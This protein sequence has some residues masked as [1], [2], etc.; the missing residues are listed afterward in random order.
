MY[1]ISTQIIK[2]NYS[3]IAL[4]KDTINTKKNIINGNKQ[5]IKQLEALLKK[6]ER[7]YKIN[8]G[9]Y[10][11]MVYE[12]KMLQYLFFY[13]IILLVVPL[14]YLFEIL[15][16]LVAV[17]GWL[18]LVTAGIILFLYKLYTN[19][20]NRDKIF[21]DQYNFGK[22]TRENILRSRLTQELNEKCE[23]EP[24]NDD[25]DFDPVKVDIGN[26]NKWKNKVPK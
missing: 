26:I 13:A 3:H 23:K 18:L 9:Q 14:L 22:P 16:K 20:Q 15:D 7:Q 6:K 12:T 8:M 25:D 10:N 19:K 11:L 2:K 24:K 5:K 17:I 4:D 1:N 21:Y